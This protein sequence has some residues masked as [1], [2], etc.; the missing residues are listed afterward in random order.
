[1]AT[2]IRL[3]HIVA[4]D[5]GEAVTDV[6]A[7]GEDPVGQATRR[8]IVQLGQERARQRTEGRFTRHTEKMESWKGSFDLC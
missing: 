8:R 1:M 4:K 6:H 3:R 5:E 2:E 7:P